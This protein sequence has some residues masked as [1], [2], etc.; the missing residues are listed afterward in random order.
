MC[1][2]KGV[3]KGLKT[4]IEQGTRVEEVEKCID[5]AASKAS[6]YAQRR[7]G[8]QVWGWTSWRNGETKGIGEKSIT[9]A[10]TVAAR[11]GVTGTLK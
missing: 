6:G 2:W 7:R 4:S 5:G 1:Q 8:R 3:R 11:K 9:G 10:D